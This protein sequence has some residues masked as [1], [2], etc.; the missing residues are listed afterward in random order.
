[1]AQFSAFAQFIPMAWNHTVADNQ[2]GY[3]AMQTEERRDA[4]LKMGR[5]A[6]QAQ[7]NKDMATLGRQHAVASASGVVASSGSALQ[8]SSDAVRN[9]EMNAASVMYRYRLEAG[10]KPKGPS[11]FDYFDMVTNITGRHPLGPLSV[12]SYFMG[13]QGIRLPS[14]G[15]FGVGS[16][17]LTDAWKGIGSLMTRTPAP[18]TNYTSIGN[19]NFVVGGEVLENN[20]PTGGM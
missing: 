7:I 2:S 4:I 15:E 14:F 18:A 10:P 20:V 17:G 6:E 8:N 1:M 13:R 5:Y 16:Q 3:A 19:G 9:L 11:G 12:L